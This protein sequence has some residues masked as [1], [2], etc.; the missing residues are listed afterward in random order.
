MAH[1]NQAYRAKEGP[2]DV[3]S[4]RTEET[5]DAGHNKWDVRNANR[6][7]RVILGHRRGMTSRSRR[8]DERRYLGDVAIAPVVALRNARRF[9][10][11]L[12]KELC[13]LILHGVLHLMGY[14]HE[15]DRGEMDRREARLRRRLKLA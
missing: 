1:W 5:W 6:V 9:G 8:G 7:R 10:R 4:F 11:A 15:T 14:D 13:I 3:L 12:Y 2:T